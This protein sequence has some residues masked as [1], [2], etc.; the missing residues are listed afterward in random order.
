MIEHVRRRA[1]LADGVDEVVVATCDQEIFDVMTQTG[2]KAIMTANTH[3]RCTTRVDE[4][5]YSDDADIM[6]IIAG[7][8]PLT[9]PE[10]ITQ[11]VKPLH[12]DPELDCTNFLSV[13]RDEKDFSDINIVKAAT[14]Q[15]G[16]IMYYSRS[17]I[18]YF[19]IQEECPIYRQTGLMAFR[20]SFLHRFTALPETPFERV[21]S[22]DMLRL[23]EH[24]HRIMG[25]PTEEVTYGVDHPKDIEKILSVL[26]T[27]TRQ[28]LLYKKTLEVYL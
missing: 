6:V 19:R 13:I 4:A 20:T 5:S 12:A 28:R 7:D 22:I 3:E 1:L 16:F 18:P 27:D 21:E 17:P 10:N 23:L 14:D 24:G 25:V 26:E 15:A 11:V 9:L 2:G 8:E